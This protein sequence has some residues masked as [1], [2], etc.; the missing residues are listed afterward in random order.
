M[1]FSS[2]LAQSTVHFKC[3][4][5]E[6][7]NQGMPSTFVIDYVAAMSC[8]SQAIF[9]PLQKLNFCCDACLCFDC[10]FVCLFV[11]VSVAYTP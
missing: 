2:F 3:G 5:E 10:L 7:P 1:L 11:L 8:I 4:F 6:D 9:N